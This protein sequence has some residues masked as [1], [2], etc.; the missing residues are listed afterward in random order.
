MTNNFQGSRAQRLID[1]FEEGDT[2]A[3]GI[4]RVLEHLA[5]AFDMVCDDEGESMVGVSVNTLDELAQELRAAPEPEPLPTPLSPGAQAVL[6]AAGRR[7]AIDSD[8]QDSVAAALRAAANQ[9]T[10]AKAMK[11]LRTIADELEGR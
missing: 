4:A 8:L 10:S 5:Y 11:H 1:E 7:Y 2:V 3:E 6:D 9:M